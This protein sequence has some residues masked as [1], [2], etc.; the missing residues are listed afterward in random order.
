MELAN[1]RPRNDKN[2]A[3][4]I[5]FE[6]RASGSWSL[7]LAQN[8]GALEGL[9]RG[10]QLPALLTGKGELRVPLWCPPIRFSNSLAKPSYGQHSTRLGI[11]CGGGWCRLRCLPLWR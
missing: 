11:L 4:T 5:S 7:A 8:H 2:Y 3:A 10:L 6:K 1:L 9:H